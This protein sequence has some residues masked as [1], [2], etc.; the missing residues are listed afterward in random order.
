MTAC[1]ACGAL[2]Q[3]YS[4]PAL[5]R[6][7][8][9]IRTGERIVDESE[10]S[11]FN[12]PGKRAEKSCDQCGRFICGLCEVELE[13]QCLCPDCLSS[14]RTK[15]KLTSLTDE[16]ILYDNI[17]LML[18]TLPILTISLTLFGA[19]AALYVCIRHWNTPLGL[20]KSRRR[21]RFVV[22]AILATLQICAWLIF[23]IS[24]FKEVTDG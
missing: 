20:M 1:P 4:F 24:I 8:D 18:A 2:Q 11:C 12:H 7:L 21:W 13:G 6:N 9:P 15:G 16:R 19:P 17:A 10:A 3:V 23:F 5:T 22:A 14:G